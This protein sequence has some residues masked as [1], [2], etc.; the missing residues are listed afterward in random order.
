MITKELFFKFIKEYQA[1]DKAIERLEIALSGKKYGCNLFDCDWFMSVGLMLDIFLNSHFKEEGQ[2]LINWWL[3]DD[4]DHIIW[5]KVDP[6]L[7]NGSSEIEYNVNELE[8][9]WNYLIKYKKD[10][11]LND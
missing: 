4:V 3:F 8:D 2:D 5:Q 9:L 7:F 11:F 6:D 10:Y 1:F